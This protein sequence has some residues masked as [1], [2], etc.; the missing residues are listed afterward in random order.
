M[1]A[2]VLEDVGKFKY[3]DVPTPEPGIGEV[4]INIKAVSICGSDVHGYDGSS[5]RR[6]PPLILGHEAS[7][8]ISKIGEG[9][10]GLKVGDDVVFNSAWYCRNCYYCKRGNFNMCINGGV[11]GVATEEYH[12]EGA[13]C[14]YI[15]VPEYI[16]YKMPEGVSYETAALIE[17]LAIACHAIAGLDIKLNDKAVIFGA[18]C[19]GLML[20]KALRVSS[21]GKI[22][23]VEVDELKKEMAK[24]NGADYIIDG[25]GNVPEEI[26]EIT[27]GIGAD[28]AIEAVG[29]AQ[30]MNNAMACLKK[31]GTLIQVG[32]ITPKVEFPLQTCVMNEIRVIGRYATNTEY[33]TALN[34]VAAGK[35]HLDDCISVAA[36][37]KN[38]QEWF[39]KLHNGEK[40][41]IKVVLKT[42]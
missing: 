41:I 1:K 38:G 2:L 15:V 33:E 23:V 12:R 6:V 30:T 7:G 3:T 18:G 17:P 40:G 29:V 24:Q 5:G 37:L 4:K 21:A 36:P 16:C 22:C 9:V 11:Y 31:T 8:V 35:V 20:L 42:Y 14:E 32:N 28:F 13:M 10:T 34:L 26:K 39:D 25:R 27:Q 19:I